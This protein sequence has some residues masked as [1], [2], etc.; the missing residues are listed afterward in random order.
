MFD[1]DRKKEE[2]LYEY[3]L[4]DRANIFV[5]FQSKMI[6]FCLYLREKSYSILIITELL[7]SCGNQKRN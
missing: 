1:R 2:I 6:Q 5:V 7:L 3:I 4:L